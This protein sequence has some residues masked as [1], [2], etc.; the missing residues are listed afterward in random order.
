MYYIITGLSSGYIVVVLH[1]NG[2][3]E[4]V[5]DGFQPLRVPLLVEVASPLTYQTALDVLVDESESR[6]MPLKSTYMLPKAAL[7]LKQPFLTWLTPL[8]AVAVATETAE[9]VVTGLALML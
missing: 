8:A 1:L 7:M 4:F 3:R 6:Q 5:V 2:P 9:V